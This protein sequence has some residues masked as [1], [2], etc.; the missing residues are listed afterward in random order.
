MIGVDTNVLVRLLVEDDERQ[1]SAAYGLVN[2]P[3]RTEDPIFVSAI[4]VIEIEWVLRKTY[5]RGKTEI[6]EAIE[7]LCNRANLVI[8]DLEAVR[9]ALQ[10]WQTGKADLA[11][12]LIAAL[13]R[14]RGARTTMT[15]DQDAAKTGAFTLLPT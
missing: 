13:A 9:A 3:E 10:A 4:V 5:Q 7:Q 15:F 8:D 11:D 12:Y 6:A 14:Q 1:F 2:A